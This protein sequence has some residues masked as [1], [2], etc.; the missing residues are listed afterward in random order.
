V[1]GREIISVDADARA[2]GLAKLRTYHAE[3]S[4]YLAM[5]RQRS[6]DYAAIARKSSAIESRVH[7]FSRVLDR[8]V[9]NP[10]ITGLDSITGQHLIYS[11]LD[12]ELHL[13]PVVS[14]IRTVASD[15]AERPA[16]DRMRPPPRHP[17]ARRRASPA[18]G[19]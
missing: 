17:R 5:L 6:D 14:D 15:L 4:A 19:W 16:G 10:I 18:A 11:L 8:L 12:I 1:D 13:K 2:H 3:Q 7:D 9:D